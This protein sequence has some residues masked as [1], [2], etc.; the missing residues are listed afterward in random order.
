[1]NKEYLAPYYLMQDQ[2]LLVRLRHPNHRIKI[3]DLELLPLPQQPSHGIYKRPRLFIRQTMIG[4]WQHQS[5]YID[6]STTIIHCIYHPLQQLGLYEHTHPYQNILQVHP[7]SHYFHPDYS[8]DQVANV[9]VHQVKSNGCEKKSSSLHLY[10]RVRC[11]VKLCSNWCP[12]MMI[13]G[14]IS[15]S[16]LI[17]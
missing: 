17:L 4:I 9:I 12:K 15:S 6:T 1:M 5:L 10:Q 7:I 2:K 16:T 14:I 13:G 11:T 8:Q 3:H